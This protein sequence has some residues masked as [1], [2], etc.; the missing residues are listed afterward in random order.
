MQMPVYS[1][2]KRGVDTKTACGGGTKI[3]RGGVS[4]CFTIFVASIAKPYV[5]S[6]QPQ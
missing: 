6:S 2:Q 4:N 5:G 3:A 1:V